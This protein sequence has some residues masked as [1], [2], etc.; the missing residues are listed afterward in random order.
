MLNLTGYNSFSLLL[1][2]KKKNSI[3]RMERIFTELEEEKLQQMI[4]L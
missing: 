4:H 2:I 3:E 1:S